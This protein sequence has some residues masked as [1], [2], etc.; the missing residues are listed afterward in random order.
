MIHALFSEVWD[1][2][3]GGSK[4]WSDWRSLI[5]G[6]ASASPVL[7]ATGLVNVEWQN[8]TSPP[9]NPHPVTDHQRFVT[10]DYV[11]DHYGYA[12]FGANPSTGSF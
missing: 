11:G 6:C 8:S 7:T 4:G 9:Q 3:G 2:G 5:T 1:L 12:K 10:G